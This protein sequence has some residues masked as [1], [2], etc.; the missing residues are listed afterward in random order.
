MLAHVSCDQIKLFLAWH[1]TIVEADACL[2]IY[3]WTQGVFGEG[4]VVVIDVCA[5]ACAYERSV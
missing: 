2:A 1:L 3:D 5:C 4:M